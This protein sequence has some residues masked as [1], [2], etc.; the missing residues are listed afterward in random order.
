MI[1]P[2]TETEKILYGAPG[3]HLRLEHA[4]SASSLVLFA[5]LPSDVLK[6]I[7]LGAPLSLFGSLVPADGVTIPLVGIQVDDVAGDSFV[8]FQPVVDP[9]QVGLWREAT[10]SSQLKV[11]F[12]NELV[13]PVIEGDLALNPIQGQEFSALLSGWKIPGVVVPESTQELALDAFEKHLKTNGGPKSSSQLTTVV[14]PIRL[15]SKEVLRLSLGMGKF[16][17]RRSRAEL[18]EEAGELCL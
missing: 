9:Q 8:P 11:S 14:A 3:A 2:T 12:V 16:M 1:R 10:R 13:I 17:K 5:K 6:A 15:E 18:K 4:S 7:H